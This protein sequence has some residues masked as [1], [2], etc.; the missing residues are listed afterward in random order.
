MEKIRKNK[1][2]T[3]IA[4]IITIILLLILSGISIQILNQNGLIKKAEKAKTTITNAQNVE[5]I[6]LAK[7]NNKIDEVISGSRD[8]ITLSKEEYERF[9]NSSTYSEE[10][11]IIGTWI[12]GKPLYRKIISLD[13]II[14]VYGPGWKNFNLGLST[15]NVDKISTIKLLNYTF[16]N[17]PAAVYIADDNLCIYISTSDYYDFSTVVLEYTKTTD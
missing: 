4:L 7:Y 1:G 14:R 9:K 2:I 10:E 5:N 16:I 15:L 17:Y 6:T 3:L 12:D 11:K 8:T 13:N